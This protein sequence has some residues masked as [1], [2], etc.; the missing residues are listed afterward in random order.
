M[1]MKMPRLLS[2]A[3]GLGTALAVGLI[4]GAGMT[5]AQPAQPAQPTVPGKG[6]RA[7]EFIAAFNR[8]DA[9][10]VAAFWTPDGDYVDQVGRQY[11]GRAALE[12]LYQKVFAELK[13]AKLAITVTSA[14]MVEPDVALEDGITEVTPADGGPPT[15]AGFSAV[16]V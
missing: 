16:L 3:L 6:P 10:A 15:V 5:P 7:M 8:G 11:K 12:K 1:H 14:R 13:G 4:V 9:R 2:L